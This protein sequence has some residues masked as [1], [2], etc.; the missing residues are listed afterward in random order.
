MRHDKVQT[1]NENYAEKMNKNCETDHEIGHGA[2]SGPSVELSGDPNADLGGKPNCGPSVDL[3]GSTSRDPNSNPNVELNGKPN[4]DPNCDPNGD[5]NVDPSGK[6]SLD[7]NADPNRS[8]RDELSGDPNV[9]PSADPSRAPNADSAPAGAASAK[10]DEIKRE[11]RKALKTYIP[12]LI[13]C[14]AVG[15]VF[16]FFAYASGLQQAAGQI[17]SWAKAASFALS[18]Y[19][20]IGVVLISLILSLNQYYQAKKLY[21]DFDENQ[22][23]GDEEED[24][25]S[26]A[27]HKLSFSVSV[28]GIGTVTAMMFFAVVFCDMD[29]HLEAHR[30]L[31]L[32]TVFF[33]VGG[34]FL[35]VRMQQLQVDFMKHMSPSMKGSVYDR[36]FH[37]KWEE[38]CDEA[39]K[40]VIYR[41]SYRAFRVANTVCSAGWAVLTVGTMI[42][43]YGC[44]PSVVIAALWL[45][46]NVTY[47]REAM[48]LEHS[49]INR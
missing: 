40:L 13:L 43:H 24:P 18:P 20:V 6:P 25:F 37:E 14:A 46:M 15:G 44:L 3:N 26:R 19:C 9:D 41:A 1:D 12:T 11:N 29:R 42:F 21:A 45:L 32:V 36:K 10:N 16:G 39:E 2:A 23:L 17:T 49:N 35:T 47:Y 27:D 8:P 4:V 5:P 22:D 48:R 30:L 7:P 38:S 34:L 31:I 28:S 33:F